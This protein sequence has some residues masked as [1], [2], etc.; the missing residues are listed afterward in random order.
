MDEARDL[1]ECTKLGEEILDLARITANK[2]HPIFQRE[3][4]VLTLRDQVLIGLWRKLYLAFESLVEDAKRG[5]S[6]SVHHL[7]TMTECF[8][9]LHY[10]D[11]ESDDNRAKIVMAEAARQKKNFFEKNPE[12]PHRDIFLEIYTEKHKGL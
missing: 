11:E 5:R 4:G 6:E 1:K 2:V 12:F 9:Y 8:I 10:V 3:K 7:K